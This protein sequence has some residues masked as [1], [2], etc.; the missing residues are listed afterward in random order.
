MTVRFHGYPPCSQSHWCDPAVNESHWSSIEIGDPGSRAPRRSG[1][2]LWAGTLEYMLTVLESQ[3]RWVIR[4]AVL[5]YCLVALICIWTKPGLHYD[6]AIDVLGA[7]HLR[8]SNEEL[9]I[10]H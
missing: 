4:G 5:W 9:Q 6:E 2:K 1:Q 7:V 8:H 3:W 10:P